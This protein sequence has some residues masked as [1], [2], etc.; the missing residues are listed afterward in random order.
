MA[1]DEWQSQKQDSGPLPNRRLPFPLSSMPGTPS[2]VRPCPPLKVSVKIHPLGTSFPVHHLQGAGFLLCLLLAFTAWPPGAPDLS[3]G[4][5]L[6]LQ[7][8]LPHG[9]VGAL[10]L[11][12]ARARVNQMESAHGF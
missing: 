12:P 8:L 10:S 7:L 9:E 11:L 6:P 3:L 4:V 5:Y 1:A 2:S